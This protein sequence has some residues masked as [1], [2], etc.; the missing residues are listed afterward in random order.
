MLSLSRAVAAA[1]GGL[2]LRT[3]GALAG[4]RAAAAS[5]AVPQ[6]A[7]SDGPDEWRA[8]LGEVRTDWTREEVESVYGQPLLELV[9]TAA[10][11]HRAHHDPLSVQKCT[12]LSIKTGGCPEDCTYCS[13][14][15]KHETAVKATRLMGLEEVYD[16]AVRAKAAGSTRFC[17]GAAWRGPSQVRE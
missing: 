12:L 3:A 2:G 15:S 16:A 4:R 14:S 9:H 13:Q 1:A 5:A 10:T 6:P 17:M 11:V 7:V 8:R